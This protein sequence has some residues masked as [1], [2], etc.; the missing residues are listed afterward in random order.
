LFIALLNELQIDEVIII[1]I[2][3]G[4]LTALEIT[5]QYQNRVKKLVL[6]SALTDKMFNNSD[7][8]FIGG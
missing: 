4:G 5:A 1:G 8:Q 7:K 3:A 2:S 6:M